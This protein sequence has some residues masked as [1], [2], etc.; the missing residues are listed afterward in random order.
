VTVFDSVGFAI[1]DFSALRYLHRLHRAARGGRVPIDLVPELG[2]PKDL[3][4]L[5]AATC[6]PRSPPG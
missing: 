4:G 1:E 6:G 3:F 2:N 5:L